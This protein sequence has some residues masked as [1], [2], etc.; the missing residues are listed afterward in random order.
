MILS[1]ENSPEISLARGATLRGVVSGSL[2]GS[3]G[4]PFVDPSRVAVSV[5]IERGVMW[6]VG[7]GKKL[8]SRWPGRGPR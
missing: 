7:D 8:C 5:L 4:S 1:S 6:H 2:R 3:A